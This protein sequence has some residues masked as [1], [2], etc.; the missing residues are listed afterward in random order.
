MEINLILSGVGGQGILTIAQALSLAAISRGWRV[1]QAEVHGMAQRGGGVQSHLRISDKPIHSDLI[2][3]GQADMI[4][5]VEPLEV[6]RYVQYLSKDGVIVSNSTPFINIPNYPPVAETLERVGSIAR[7]VLINADALAKSAG[8][9]R[10]SNIVMVGA[11][12]GFLAFDPEE[13]EAAVTRMFERKGE[14]IVSINRTAFRY[15]RQA[16]AAY[17]AGMS[18]GR[19]G[20]E[21]RQWLDALEPEELAEACRPRCSARGTK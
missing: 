15:G 2:P 21:V 10:A 14:K 20:Q 1:K 16:A 13:L 12:S 4:L 7:H 5:S 18:S 6:L 9:V 3:L 11:A 19:T 17:E 8:S